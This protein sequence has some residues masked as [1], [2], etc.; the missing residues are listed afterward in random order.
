MWELGSVKKEKN[1]GKSKA[2][3]SMY[4]FLFRLKYFRFHFR[5]LSA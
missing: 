2:V 3:E 1:V 5:V 4:L